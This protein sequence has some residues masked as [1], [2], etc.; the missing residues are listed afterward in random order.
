MSAVE[1]ETNP[2]PAETVVDDFF[3][4]ERARDHVRAVVKRSGTSFGPGMA[5]LS[6]PQREAMYAIYAFCRE[7]DDIADDGDAAPA[8]RMVR[9]QL[10]RDEIEALFAGSP[11]WLTTLALLQPVERFALPKQEFIAMIEG[12][13]MDAREIMLAPDR[14]GLAAYTRRV[15]GSVGVLSMRV[16]GPS[17]ERALEFALKLGDAFQLTNILRDVAEDAERGRL[18]IPSDYLS[19]YE[20]PVPATPA[21]L[22]AVLGHPGL[23]NACRDLALEAEKLFAECR[24]LLEGMDRKAVRPALV[25]WRIYESYLIALQERGWQRPLE[26]VRFSK[27]RKLWLALSGMWG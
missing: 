21:E 22:P 6:R 2:S 5:I 1:L 17:D 8:D 3:S 16:F 26:T 18:Y 19:V 25:M 11:T 7:V 14:A 15:A 24:N 13:E 10:W 12:M 4:P 9:L 27:P 20:L 23:G